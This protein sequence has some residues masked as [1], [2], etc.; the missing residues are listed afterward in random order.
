MCPLGCP[1]CVE[2]WFDL[3]NIHLQYIK[4]DA[5]DEGDIP[6]KLAE[7]TDLF[8]LCL[9][10]IMCIT[11]IG[12]SQERSKHYKPSVGGFLSNPVVTLSAIPR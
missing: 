7:E 10:S 9:D 11:C 8:V 1:L 3:I 6:R 4:R 5:M 12:S 2:I